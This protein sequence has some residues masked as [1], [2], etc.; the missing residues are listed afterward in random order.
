MFWKSKTKNSGMYNT[1]SIPAN[2]VTWTQ[3][4]TNWNGVLTEAT[5][6]ANNIDYTRVM[7][8]VPQWSQATNGNGWV[9]TISRSSNDNNIYITLTRGGGGSGSV[10]TTN[11]VTINTQQTITGDK[12]FNAN[13]EFNKVVVV[14][15]GT[16]DDCSFAVQR[17]ANHANYA[18]FY[19]GNARLGFIGKA[20]ANDT[21]LTLKAETGDLVLNCGS[22]TQSI[23]ASGKNISNVKDPTSAQHAATKN[24]VDSHLGQSY[25]KIYNLPNINSLTD[26]W[27]IAHDYQNMDNNFQIEA[28]TVYEVLFKQNTDTK[29]VYASCFIGVNN[30]SYDNVG[31][32]GIIPWGSFGTDSVIIAVS[33]KAR[34]IKVWAKKG[35]GTASG[36]NN[37]GTTTG[38]YIRKIGSGTFA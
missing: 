23:N 18:G 28:N 34:Q 32:S 27:T 36:T 1:L 10:D 37:W 5:M 4:G 26:N 9:T 19:N 14:H 30:A 15:N 25:T 16:N 17:D 6:L 12:Q 8:V 24:Y 22:D 21:S 29:D 33:L 2:L 20:S 38:I 3:N 13:V 35:P 31:V 11:L 7:N